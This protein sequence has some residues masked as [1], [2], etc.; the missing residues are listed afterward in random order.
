[1]VNSVGVNSIGVRGTTRPIERIDAQIAD[2]YRAG[3]Q[4]G[5]LKRPTQ[6]G[7]DSGQE[8]AGRERFDQIVIGAL[9]EATDAVLLGRARGQHDD[10]H[11]RLPAKLPQHG[12]SVQ[13]GQIT[14]RITRPNLPRAR[15]QPHARLHRSDRYPPAKEFLH[16]LAQAF[17]V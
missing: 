7:T 13:H 14:S 5:S 1:M 9:T 3:C 6:H 15:H 11:V 17:I 4:V 10:R 16:Q 12:E 2:L 8:L